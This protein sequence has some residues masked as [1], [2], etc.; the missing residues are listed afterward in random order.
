MSAPSGLD[1]AVGSSAP[2]RTKVAV[3]WLPVVAYTLLIW[4]LS[5]QV[6]EFQIIEQVPLQD[7]GVHFL[8]Y[9][10]M[11]FF[12]AHAVSTTW[13]RRGA[14][15]VLV[16]VIMTAATGLLDELHQAFVP[17][18]SSDLVDLAADV[19]GALC[20]ALF[21]AALYAWVVRR[22]ARRAFPPQA[23]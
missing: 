8:E 10:A 21:Y 19:A 1:E 11:G 2:A 17:G 7:K 15:S 12:I 4:W 14:A 13:P 20:A 9:G 5:S 6:L 22:R 16:S 3:A 23:G 18:R